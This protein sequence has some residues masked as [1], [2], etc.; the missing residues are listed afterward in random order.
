MVRS[1]RSH[2][3]PPAHEVVNA[4]ETVIRAVQT[5]S[6]RILV[7]SSS[8]RLCVFRAM[9][10]TCIQRLSTGVLF[11]ECRGDVYLDSITPLTLRLRPLWASSVSTRCNTKTP[12]GGICLRI[13]NHAFI[14]QEGL[15]VV[16]NSLCNKLIGQLNMGSG[17]LGCLALLG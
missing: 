1:D 14:I 12:H 9:L 3:K 10:S 8:Q 11:D 13:T 7:K 5:D 6:S 16:K 4:A 2:G 15:A 17:S